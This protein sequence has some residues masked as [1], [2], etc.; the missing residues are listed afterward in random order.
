MMRRLAPI[1]LAAAASA[2]AQYNDYPT[3]EYDFA[4]NRLVISPLKMVGGMDP[5]KRDEGPRVN[6]AWTPNI[7]IL[8]ARYEYVIGVDGNIGVGPLATLY[9]G[10]DSV[11]ATGW[12]AGVYGR[13]YME[14]GRGGYVQFSAQWF[15]QSGAKVRDGKATDT[16][17]VLL[18]Q[19]HPV[20]VSG[21]QISPVLGYCYLIGEH[22]ILEGQ[23]GFTLGNYTTTVD[24]GPV[25]TKVGTSANSETK[26]YQTGNNWG[27]YYFAQISLG[28]AW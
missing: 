13:Y 16:N 17:G 19:Q 7:D 25:T 2:L 4:H 22:L 9:L 24:N 20:T 6:L 27:G 21:P 26:I 23:M 8:E 12:A 5:T 1:L 15:D 28:V 14:L 18:A 10:L 3:G 11:K